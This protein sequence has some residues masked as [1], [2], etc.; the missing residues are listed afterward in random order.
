MKVYT[1]GACSGNPGPGGWGFAIIENDNILYSDASFFEHTTNNKMEL[2]AAIKG[3]EFMKNH[4][5][6]ISS[7]PVHTDS[8]YTM[9]SMKDWVHNWKKKNW[10]KSNGKPIENPEL[11]KKLY[12]LCYESGITVDWVKVKAHQK[13]TSKDYDPFNDYVDQLATGKEQPKKQ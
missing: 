10:K 11:I 13:K 5:P 9:N 4:Y 3:I 2:T 7:F 8:T 6:H 1:D 12:S